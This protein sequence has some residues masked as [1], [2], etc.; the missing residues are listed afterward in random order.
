MA[1]DK[2]EDFRATIKK[3]ILIYE[4]TLPLPQPVEVTSHHLAVGVFDPE[5]YMEV[6]LDENDPVHFAGL[7]SGACTFDI[8]EDSDN[9]IY[10]GMVYPLVIKLNCATS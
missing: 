1:L 10:F 8:K 3:N 6:D 4:F 2:V 7:P 9:P 5:Y